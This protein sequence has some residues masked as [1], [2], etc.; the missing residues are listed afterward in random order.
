VNLR[1]SST[2]LTKLVGKLSTMNAV[3]SEIIQKV[4]RVI[5]VECNAISQLLPVDADSYVSA[6]NAILECN[7]KVVITGMG[8]SGIVAQKIA[9]TM[10]STGTHAIFMH[11][12]EALH[13][14]LG[15]VR[16][17]DLVIAISKSGESHELNSLI[18]A[19]RQIKTQLIGITAGLTSTL[20]TSSDIVLRLPSAE[21]AC[22]LNLA[23][24]SSTTMSLVIGD[25]L[26]MAVME[27]RGFQ[28]EDFAVYHPGGKLGKR[29]LTRVRDL[30]VPRERCGVLAESRTTMPEVLTALSEFGVGIVAF[31]DDNGRFV[32]ILTDGD[33]R[34]TLQVAGE[35]F[36]G[37][38][39]RDII[40]RSPTCVAT[41]V[42][43]L[44]ALRIME[45]RPK[46]LNVLPVTVG[47]NFCGVLRNHD[48]VQ[49]R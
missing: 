30:M 23:P 9:A 48:V 39:L 43:A 8:K 46:T 27:L 37:V 49:L 21:E 44:D 29:L 2:E 20:A 17:A 31:E 34:R 19:L 18:P 16:P 32:G 47:Q 26:A 45:S 10:A 40:N 6:V 36:F 11:P 25:A 3:D 15:M 14:D 13:G 12:A 7:G 22:P 35:S 24:T 41:D 5:Q 38:P 1:L 33:I 4:Q 28:P 42:L